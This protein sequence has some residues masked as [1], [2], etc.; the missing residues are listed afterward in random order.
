MITSFKDEHRF[1][2]NFWPARIEFEGDAYPS[3]EHAYVASKTANRELRK[4]LLDPLV[5]SG[6][7]KR[8][9]KTFKLRSDWEKIKLIVMENFLRQKFSDPG[10]E[11]A[12]MD[13]APHELIEGN[14]WGDV[15][16][17]QCPIGIGENHLGRLLMEIRSEKLENMENSNA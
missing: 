6:K 9:G 2:S 12:L 15:F 3:V 17:G 13:T 10:L 8:I 1:L 14:T 11:K 4:K 7:A 5:T 16:W